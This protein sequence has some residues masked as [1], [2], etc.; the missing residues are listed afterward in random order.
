M[1]K[2]SKVGKETESSQS[3]ANAFKSIELPSSVPKIVDLGPSYTPGI[4]DVICQ[5]GKMAFANVGN[6]RLRVLVNANRS[7]YIDP[8]CNKAV[9]SLI[10][11][12]II[13][14]IRGKGGRFVRFDMKRKIWVEVSDRISREKVGHALR[15]AKGTQESEGKSVLGSLF[16][17][18]QQEEARNL[19]AS[20]VSGPGKVSSPDIPTTMD[21]CSF[22]PPEQVA[23]THPTKTLDEP[24]PLHGPC[25]FGNVDV[26]LL[27]E[28]LLDRTEEEEGEVDDKVTHSGAVP[29]ASQQLQRP[30]PAHLRN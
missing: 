17:R 6:R 2:M 12:S 21:Y 14:F 20:A 15:D 1:F 7:K 10:V 26:R 29:S 11:T 13:D 27:S 8:T 3:A 30:G 16:V 19:G 9:R 18:Q 24:L 28:V 22:E 23:S 25:G 5:R 4:H